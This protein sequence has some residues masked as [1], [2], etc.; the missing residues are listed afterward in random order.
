MSCGFLIHAS[1]TFSSRTL[2]TTASS[3]SQHLMRM[4]AKQ[5]EDCVTHCWTEH[6]YGST[7]SSTKKPTQMEYM[8]TH[9]LSFRPP[10]SSSIYR[11]CSRVLNARLGGPR[12]VTQSATSRVSRALFGQPP[13][14]PN[15]AVSQSRL[16]CADIAWVHPFPT[17]TALSNALKVQ[18]EPDSHW[19]FTGV[20]T[21]TLA[22]N[23]SQ[24]LWRS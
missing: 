6:G 24:S 2:A 13:S 1:F 11:Q 14:H 18:Q 20:T 4:R 22:S 10:V 5:T 9:S 17:A 7:R 23:Q 16:F 3:R 8:Q 21:S 19:S 15:P 12:C